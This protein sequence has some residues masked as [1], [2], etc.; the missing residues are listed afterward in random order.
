MM[1]TVFCPGSEMEPVSAAGR[2]IFAAPECMEY[3]KAV[4]QNAGVIAEEPLLREA[5]DAGLPAL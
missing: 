2:P 5:P 4:F 3:A 1:I